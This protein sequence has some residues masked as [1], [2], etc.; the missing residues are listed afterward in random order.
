LSILAIRQSWHTPSE[1]NNS[2]WSS[3]HGQQ[4]DDRR[5]R[6]TWKVRRAVDS[7]GADIPRAGQYRIVPRNLLGKIAA[8]IE[9][10]GWGPKPTAASP[11]EVEAAR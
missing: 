11:I 6:T 2:F 7:I 10:R 3:Q 1:L 8:E 5:N 9:R 4:F